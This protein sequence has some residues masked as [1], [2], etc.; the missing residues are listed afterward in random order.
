MGIDPIA[1][2]E[3]LW[4]AEELLDM[5]L[6]EDVTEFVSVADGTVLYVADEEEDVFV[7][8]AQKGLSKN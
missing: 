2:L 3:L 6:P 4:I 7:P 1:E 5:P 8:V